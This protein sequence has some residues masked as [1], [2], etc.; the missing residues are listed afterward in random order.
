MS[1]LLLKLYTYDYA[2][3]TLI[4]LY[5]QVVLLESDVSALNGVLPLQAAVVLEF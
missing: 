5:L 2:T 4:Q 3:S 1:S